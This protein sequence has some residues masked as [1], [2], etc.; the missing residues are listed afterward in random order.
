M[1]VISFRVDDATAALIDALA[2][3]HESRSDTIRRALADALRLQRR[4]NMR[5]EAALCAEDAADLAE[6]AAV[7]EDL[8]DL[9]AW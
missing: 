2:A 7:R 1:T 9:R 6:S 5:A 3:P 8:D 4:E